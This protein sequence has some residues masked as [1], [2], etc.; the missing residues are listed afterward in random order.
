MTEMKDYVSFRAAR[1]SINISEEVVAGVVSGAAAEVEGIGH[2]FAVVCLFVC[3]F[4]EMHVFVF[5]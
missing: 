2:F 4:I 3:F 5:F 1:G